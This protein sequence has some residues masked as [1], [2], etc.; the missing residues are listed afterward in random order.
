[1]VEDG[2]SRNGQILSDDEYLNIVASLPRDSYG[3]FQL[4]I[5]ISLLIKWE[6]KLFKKLL[7]E[8]DLPDA[9]N[10]RS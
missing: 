6:L 2:C 8:I 10:Y 4:M 9:L 1:M 7:S 5:L 3:D